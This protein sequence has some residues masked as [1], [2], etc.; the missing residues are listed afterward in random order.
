MLCMELCADAEAS[1][2]R[3]RLMKQRPRPGKQS[4]P[5]SER[6]VDECAGRSKSSFDCKSITFYARKKLVSRE[7]FVVRC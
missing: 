2:R 5:G 3:P 4:L 1:R 7:L 6:H